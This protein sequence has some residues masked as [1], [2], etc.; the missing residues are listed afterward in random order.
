MDK[1]K[2]RN[3]L[4]ATGLYSSEVAKSLKTR[5][6]EELFQNEETKET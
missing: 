1:A 6:A 5:Q 2:L 3:T 4:R